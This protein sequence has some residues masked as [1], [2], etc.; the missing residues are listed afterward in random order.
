[1]TCPRCNGPVFRDRDQYGAYASCLYCG[2]VAEEGAMGP[3]EQQRHQ[4]RLRT[5]EP[6]R[7]GQKL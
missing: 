3:E 4:E 7:R 5:K 6:S 1:M 2:Y